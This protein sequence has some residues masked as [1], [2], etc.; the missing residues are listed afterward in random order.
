[1][2]ATKKDDGGQVYPGPATLDPLGRV[3]APPVIGMTFRQHAA[4]EIF[5]V[6][7]ASQTKTVGEC[8]EIAVTGA[9]L[10]I[11]QLRKVQ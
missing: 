2:D 4:L 6:V 5:K 8:A 11:A 9:D 10:L 3:V 1:M 7:R